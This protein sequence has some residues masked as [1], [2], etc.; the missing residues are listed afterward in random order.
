MKF[1]RWVH[2]EFVHGIAA[3]SPVALKGAA[4]IRVRLLEG[5]AMDSATE[6]PEIFIRC[7]IAAK[8]T[9]DWHGLILGGRA[10]D[11]ESRHGLGFR[12]ALGYHCL[13]TRSQA[14]AVRGSFPHAEGPGLR[15]FI[16]PLGGGFLVCSSC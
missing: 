2:P 4:V 5:K 16:Q 7:N 6:G 1:E 10:L 8:G 9:L 14:P 12:P 13:D 3:G 11:C 15:L